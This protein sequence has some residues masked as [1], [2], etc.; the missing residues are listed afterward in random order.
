MTRTRA[1]RLFQSM[2][3]RPEH[4]GFGRA[5]ER[6]DGHDRED[7]RPSSIGRT[8][9]RLWEPPRLPYESQIDE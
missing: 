3:N 8:H 7:F 9:S 6:Y 5:A 2:R 4:N 1:Q